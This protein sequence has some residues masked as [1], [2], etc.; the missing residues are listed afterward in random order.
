MTLLRKRHSSF[1][2]GFTLIELMV[3]L[4]GLGVVLA[5]LTL[6]IRQT[7]GSFALR[8]AAS[9]TTSELRRAQATALAKGSGYAYQ[10][11]FLASGGLKIYEQGTAT[12]VRLVLPPNEW[13][14]TVTIDMTATTFSSCAAPANPANKCVTFQPL[15]YV[16]QGGAAALKGGAGT[17]VTYYINVTAATGK[18]SV[19]QQ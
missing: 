14:P 8:R 9:I 10:V 12:P 17:Q 6:G 16:S 7:I 13:P 5:I 19:T 15:G 11:E 1:E 3:V 18:V 4:A 2:A